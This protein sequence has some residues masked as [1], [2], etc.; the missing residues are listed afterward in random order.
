MIEVSLELTLSPSP[1][2]FFKSN[3]LQG[4]A[5]NPLLESISFLLSWISLCWFRGHES[6]PTSTLFL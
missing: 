2:G 1:L 4:P 6:F 5:T 3:Q